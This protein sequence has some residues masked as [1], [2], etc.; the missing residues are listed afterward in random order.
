MSLPLELTPVEGRGIKGV[1]INCLGD[2]KLS[3]KPQLEDIELGEMDIFNMFVLHE[4]LAITE[5]IGIPLM[6]KRFL[7]HPTWANR[8]HH[9]ILCYQ[10]PHENPNATSIHLRIDPSSMPDPSRGILSWGLAPVTWQTEVG[11][12][13]MLRKDMEPLSI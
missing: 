13:I 8:K 11:S 6:I 5:R 7:P 10:N 1:R 3:N 4:T 12:P 9:E 2:Q